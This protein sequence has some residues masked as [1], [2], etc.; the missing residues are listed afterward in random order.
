MNGKIGCQRRRRPL[1]ALSQKLRVKLS[2]H[3]PQLQV[4]GLD[5][6]KSAVAMK[7]SYAS[8]TVESPA[9]ADFAYIKL[10]ISPAA[11]ATESSNS[12][13]FFCIC[14]IFVEHIPLF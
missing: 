14:Q 9:T 5:H 12:C 8:K 2:I 6:A 4:V 10:R 7:S 13:D 11:I 3:K 1:F